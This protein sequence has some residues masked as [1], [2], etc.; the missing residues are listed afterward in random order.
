MVAWSRWCFIF[1]HLLV[2]ALTQ[3]CGA[4][5]PHTAWPESGWGSALWLFGACA[6]RYPKTRL[7]ESWLP[8][9][10]QWRGSVEH[11][12]CLPVPNYLC[13]RERDEHWWA[14]FKFFNGNNVPKSTP[15]LSWKFPAVT[16]QH[17]LALRYIGVTFLS[18]S[19]KDFLPPLLGWK[20]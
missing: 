10:Q 3:A 7:L 14:I 16:G 9:V 15:D 6:H 17:H 18:P 13:H 5:F 19:V 2:T 8:G 4:L 11:P 20:K 12:P 1:R